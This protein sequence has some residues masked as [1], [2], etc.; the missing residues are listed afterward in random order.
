MD[1]ASMLRQILGSLQQNTCQCAHPFR[2]SHSF[3]FFSK[4]GKKEWSQRNARLKSCAPDS[5]QESC[6]MYISVMDSLQARICAD[7]WH[8]AF[9]DHG[10]DVSLFCLLL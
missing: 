7:R 8:S 3:A 2:A 10:T 5:L 1:L 4:K 9:H 6:Q